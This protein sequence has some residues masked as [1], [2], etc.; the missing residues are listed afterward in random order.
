MIFTRYLIMARLSKKNVI[1]H[2][3]CVR[4]LSTLFSEAFLILR[5]T[6]QDR[7]KNLYLSSCKVPVIFVRF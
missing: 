4:I 6:E 7:M 2:K 5:R 1:E 3:M